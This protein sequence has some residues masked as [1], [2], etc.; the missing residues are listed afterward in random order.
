[1]LDKYHAWLNAQQFASML[2]DRQQAPITSLETLN[3]TII[4]KGN[5]ATF[6][7]ELGGIKFELYHDKGETDDSIWL[8]IPDKKL[9]CTGDLMISSYPNVGNPYK[10][11]RYPHDWALAMERMM[12]KDAEYLLP[13]HG[14][15][16]EGKENVREVLSITAEAMH[17]VHDEVV[18]RMNEG[19]WFEQIYHEMLEIF[20]DKFK[21]H[22]ILQPIYGCYQFAIH[23]AY[24]LYHGWYNTGNPTD[25]FPA[26]S[27]DIASEFLSIIDLTKYMEHAKKL[28]QE[29]KFQLALHLLDVVIKAKNKVSKQILLD[30]LKLKHEI[31]IQ[32]IK[33]ETS[34]IAKNVLNNGAY[35]IKTQIKNLEKDMK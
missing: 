35:Q 18:K 23:A 32:K 11:Q 31:L 25:L 6:N 15:L 22:Y 7:F 2:G 3:P 16:I 9:I 21:N 29:G 13:G 10:V 17:F 14:R 4:M 5:D 24:R 30:A 12:E 33:N 19:K 1:M 8:W 26:K 34:F 27:E 20:P 28:F